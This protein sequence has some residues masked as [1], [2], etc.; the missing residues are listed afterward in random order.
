MELCNYVC[1]E[2]LSFSL[3]THGRWLACSHPLGFVKLNLGCLK[4][5]RGKEGRRK[6]YVAAEIA[7]YVVT[8]ILLHIMN[9]FLLKQK[10]K[11]PP[12]NL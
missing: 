3:R 7:R 11:N 8:D 6:A 4:E 1:F 10:S 2:S 5:E 9:P 12:E